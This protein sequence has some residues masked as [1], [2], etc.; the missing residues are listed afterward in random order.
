MMIDC[1]KRARKCLIF[2]IFNAIISLIFGTLIGYY[3]FKPW[4]GALLGALVGLGIGLVIEI[5]LFRFNAESWLY[6]RRVLIAILVECLLAVFV[7]GPFAFAVVETRAHPH[8]ICCMTP[9]DL[10]A[11]SYEEFRVESDPGLIISGWYAPPAGGKDALVV[12]LHGG[13]GDRLGTAWH[14][15]VLIAAG[16]GVVM[17]DQRG[18]GE[19]G[20]EIT[21]FGWDDAADLAAV[22]DWVAEQKSISRDRIGVAGLSLGGQI[23]I[24]AAAEDPDWVHP[25]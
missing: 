23:A 12:L 18:L 15:E 6:R 20:G 21:T 25:L 5:G 3:V 16:Y 4:Q 1:F 24:N 13:D 14:A 11:E 19:S 10:G 9:F 17:Y 2:P 8:E 7:V 22:L